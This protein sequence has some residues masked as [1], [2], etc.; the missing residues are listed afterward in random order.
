MKRVDLVI[1][2]AGAAAQAGLDYARKNGARVHRLDEDGVH[3]ERLADGWLA[4]GVPAHRV[5]LAG[6]RALDI[7]QRAGGEVVENPA[8]GA[9]VP[10]PGALA[11]VEVAGQ[12]LGVVG[13]RA[14]A[15]SGRFRA[16]LLLAT[17]D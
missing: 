6:P 10:A 17:L 4:G 7:W 8:I 11:G 13:A 3:L 15:K 16:R 2:G 5:L 1:L 14:E 12:A 9:K